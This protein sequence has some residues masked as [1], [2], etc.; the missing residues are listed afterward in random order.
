MG[1]NSLHVNVE[2]DVVGRG[3]IT[4]SDYLVQICLEVTDMVFVEVEEAD[5]K[6]LISLVL[7]DYSMTENKYTR[8]GEEE[9]DGGI[10][11]PPK[12]TSRTVST[13]AS[14]SGVKRGGRGGGKQASKDMRPMSTPLYSSADIYSELSTILSSRIE[15]HISFDCHVSIRRWAVLAF[16]WLCS[17]QK[18]LLDMGAVML[19][20]ANAW[21]PVMEMMTCPNFAAATEDI[22]GKASVVAPSLPLFKGVVDSTLTAVASSTKRKKRKKGND[23]SSSSSETE[24]ILWFRFRHHGHGAP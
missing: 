5:S 23:K 4:E 17:G 10:A 1:R 7:H 12:K 13:S 3:P 16:G 14:S 9:E 18:R 19:S 8:G 22:P 6:R 2:D 11:E 15:N 24:F 20:N 21:G